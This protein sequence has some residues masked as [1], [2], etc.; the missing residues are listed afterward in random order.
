MKPALLV[1]DIQKAFLEIS[2]VMTQS[3][4]EAIRYTNAAIDFFREKELPIIAIQHMNEADQLVPGE[5]GFDLPESLKILP[6]D[7]RIHKTYSNSFNRTP[8]INHLQ[9]LGVDTVI[10]TGFCAEHCVLSTYHGAR[11]YDLTPVML[12]GSLASDVLEN[13]AF[14]ENI[15]ETITLGALKTFLS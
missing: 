9:E 4:H 3:I 14:V 11:D 8:L 2:P 6:S 13:I 15:C 5:A 10:L 7:V 12:R 1:I